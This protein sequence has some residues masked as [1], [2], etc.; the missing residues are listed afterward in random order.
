MEN[1]KIFIATPC[2]GGLVYSSYTQSLLYTCMLLSSK[3]IKFEVKF[4][5]NQIVTRARNMLCSLL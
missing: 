3:N 2:Y 5:N 4:I 1:I